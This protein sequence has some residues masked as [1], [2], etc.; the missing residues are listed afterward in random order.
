M[1]PVSHT[2]LSGV[3]SAAFAYA[4]H[5]WWATIVC[6]LSGIFID[7]DHFL[8]FALHKKKIPFR[9]KEL[10]AFCADE[11][12]GRMYLIL[13]SYEL[14][15]LYWLAVTFYQADAVWIGLG[16][17]VTIHMIADQVANPLKPLAYFLSY[18]IK[19]GFEKRNIFRP[20]YYAKMR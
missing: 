6:F 17:G 8:D 14:F 12:D 20:E 18:R 10:F 15:A 7:L 9:Y 5:A 4:T 11:K 16:V 13:H 1:K 19:Q 3:T 2:I